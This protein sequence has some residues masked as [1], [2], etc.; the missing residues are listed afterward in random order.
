MGDKNKPK[1]G[2]WP[3]IKPFVNGGTSGML[4]TCVIQPV[5]MIKVRIQLGQGSAA[6]VT[7]T[8]IKE[9][10]IGALYKGLSAGLLRQATYTYSSSW[11]IQDS[12]KQSN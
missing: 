11:I 6:Q 12:D 4:A 2:V 5:D 10:G 8:M 7:R 1:S 3:T 9:E